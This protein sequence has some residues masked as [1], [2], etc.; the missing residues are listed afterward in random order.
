MVHFYKNRPP[1]ETILTIA[2]AFPFFI[3]LFYYI[4]SIIMSPAFFSRLA[5]ATAV[6]LFSTFLFVPRLTSAN[7][8]N[9]KDN[10]H[11]YYYLTDDDSFDAYNTVSAEIVRLQGIYGVTV[12]TSSF[13]GTQVANGYTS[14]VYPH[15][16]WPSS[17]LYAHF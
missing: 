5:I 13:G 10:T 12:N 9:G 14:N 6:C 17:L 4:K 7:V 2:E 11:Y 1:P 3:R 8:S 16:I 15:Q